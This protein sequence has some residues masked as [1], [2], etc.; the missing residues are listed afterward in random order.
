MS[1]KEYLNKKLFNEELQNLP[2]KWGESKELAYK[3]ANYFQFKTGFKKLSENLIGAPDRV[4]ITFR[5]GEYDTYSIGVTLDKTI[6]LDFEEKKIT[7]RES[8]ADPKLNYKNTS[9]EYVTFKK[10]RMKMKEFNDYEQ[11]IKAINK[12]FKN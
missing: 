12:W 1:Y 10:R 2:E 11:A 9:A 8:I 6:Y 3:I 4:S 7:N 5:N